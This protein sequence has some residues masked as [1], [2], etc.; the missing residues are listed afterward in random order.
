M[1]KHRYGALVVK[2]IG[3]LVNQFMQR[4]TNRHRVQDKDEKRQQN[5]HAPL[6]VRFEMAIYQPHNNRTV[7]DLISDASVW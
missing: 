4:G 7:A 3:V 2:R 5:G 6:A 1:R